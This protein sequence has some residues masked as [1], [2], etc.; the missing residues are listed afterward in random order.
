MKLRK[1]EIEPLK[2]LLA[3][4]DEHGIP[5]DIWDLKRFHLD[6]AAICA[7]ERLTQRLNKECPTQRTLTS[8][9]ASE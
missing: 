6:D 2:A 9:S 4:F 5:D 1:D 3:I 8:P 7:I